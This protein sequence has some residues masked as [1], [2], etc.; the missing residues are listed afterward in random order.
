MLTYK[1]EKEFL[2]L[3]Q[4]PQL[5]LFK[6]EFKIA[7]KKNFIDIKFEKRGYSVNNKVPEII[8]SK[9]QTIGFFSGAGGLDIGAQLAGSKVISS[10]DF[11]RDSVATM[12][13]NNYF[14]HTKHFHK[15]IKEMNSKDYSKIISENNP[16]KLILVGGPPCQPFSKAGYW[17]TH[18]NRLGS[19]DPRNMI[20]QYLR[21][22]DELKPDG[23]L[24]E[25]VESLLHPKNVQ[26]VSELKE[27]IDKLGYNF[28]V[29]RANSLD[30]GVPQKR[31][32]VFFIASKKPIQG[33]PIKTHGTDK[34]II[35]NPKLKPYERVIDWIGK[36]DNEKYFEPEELT[37]GKTYDEELKQIPPGKNYF[38]LTERDGH[39]N[40]KF[41]ANKR[42]WSFLLKL[43]PNL[44]SWT[45]A[46]QPG[47]WV[48]PFHWNNRR[49]RVPEAAALQTF[50]EDYHFVGSRRSIQKQIGNAVPSLLGEAIVK[51][52]MNNI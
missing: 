25:N 28:I 9:I 51:H 36:F 13:S 30:F 12:K 18:K 23:F 52:I 38:A 5:E 37:T 34:E 47:P 21:I 11:D 1:L 39:P 45:I 35:L 48:G 15:D 41:E 4:E 26:A 31:K 50:P 20:G 43:H 10:L 7:E 16:E 8:D 27:T 24:L 6:N 2:S 29:Y 44:P 42:F 17:V 33:E 49:L 22:V 46:A 19:E 32:R 14:A 40:P 3:L